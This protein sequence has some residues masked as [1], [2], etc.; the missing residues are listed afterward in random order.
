MVNNGLAVAR[1]FKQ[2]YKEFNDLGLI[3]P[4]LIIVIRMHTII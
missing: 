1:K 4:N 3:S 2:I